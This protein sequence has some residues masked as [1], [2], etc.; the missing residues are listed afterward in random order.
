MNRLAAFYARYRQEG[1]V[2]LAL[3]FFLLA[4][5]LAWQAAAGL[6][7]F[8]AE[9]RQ[10]VEYVLDTEAQGAVRAERITELRLMEGVVA[11]SRQKPCTLEIGSQSL[12][13]TA[14]ESGYLAR[15]YGIAPAEG[16]VW[17][18]E[19]A[20]RRIAGGEAGPSVR[21]LCTMD[22]RTGTLE[23]TLLKALPDEMAVALGAS[24]TL[25]D[26]AQLRVRFDGRALS[27]ARIERLEALGFS[28]ADRESLLAE[29]FETRLLLTRL[30]YGGS[31]ALLAAL[32]GRAYLQRPGGA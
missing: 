29:E 17:L 3:V 28:V 11:V 12:N 13:V 22:D 9:A 18:G 19:K 30:G 24:A 1:R 15:C 23:L 7:S 10:P 4:G 16:T 32:L 25:G 26:D 21:K 2:K 20:F 8:A 14:L 31:A 27:G 5:H 6:A